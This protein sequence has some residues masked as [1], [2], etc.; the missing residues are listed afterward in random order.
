MAI[1]ARLKSAFYKIENGF[2][3]MCDEAGRSTGKRLALGPGDDAH[4]IAGRLTREARLKRIGDGDFNR[5]IT[6]GP[7][8]VG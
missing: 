2:V 5:Q 7:S 8:G 6:Y 3:V 1:P 4:R